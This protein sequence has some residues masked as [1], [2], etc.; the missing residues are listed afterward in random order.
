MGK[1][2]QVV[3][4]TMYALLV[5]KDDPIDEI[6]V[7]TT[8]EGRNKLLEVDLPSKIQELC[9]RFKKDVPQFSP[10]THIYVAHEESV[11]LAD[12]RTDK[13]NKLFPNLIVDVIRKHTEDSNTRL[14]CS[15]AGGR[16]TMSVA[17]AFALSLFGR[18]QDVLSHV[19]VSPDFEKSGKFYPEDEIE[20]KQLVLAEFSYIRLREK[21]PLLKENPHASYTELV[22]LAQ[23]GL[24]E[25]LVQHPLTFDIKKRSISIGDKKLN[26][27]PYEFAFYQL[28]ATQ[29]KPLPAGKKFTNELEEKFSS[30]YEKV[31]VSRRDSINKQENIEQKI[32]KCR[33]SI[34]E[35]LTKLLGTEKAQCYYIQ[36]EGGYGNKTYR[37]SLPR[38]KVK[39]RKG[40]S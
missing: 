19:L 31:R 14:H 13:D 21:L 2:P 12:I 28:V 20:S 10:S 7:I 35:K 3:T 32:T 38:K 22:Q 27:T 5:Q 17:M 25:L 24:D 40:K 4:E 11:E 6:Y 37:I 15:I 8:A 39:I 23:Q 1:T 9:L 34:N 26:L 36:S 29:R 33:S 30:L 18:K 16:K